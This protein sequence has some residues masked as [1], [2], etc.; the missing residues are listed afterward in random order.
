MCFKYKVQVH[1]GKLKYSSPFPYTIS[2]F[3][4]LQIEII[5]PENSTKI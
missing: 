2:N 3:K 5:H 4:D 1:H